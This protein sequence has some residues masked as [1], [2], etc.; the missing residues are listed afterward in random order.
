MI[1][2]PHRQ[3]VLELAKPTLDIT[4]FLVNRHDLEH[5][6][7]CFTRGDHVLAFDSLLTGQTLRVLEVA[8]GPLVE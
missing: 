7:R 2:R 3:H 5:A 8:E 6:Q 4:Q 1:N